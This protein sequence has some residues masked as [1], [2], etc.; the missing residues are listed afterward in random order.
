MKMK[1]IKSTG[2]CIM[3]SRMM[4]LIRDTAYILLIGWLCE[5]EEGCALSTVESFRLFLIIITANSKMFGLTL[6]P[7]NRDKALSGLSARNVLRD[8]MAPSS[9]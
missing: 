1:G 2:H 7:S 3:L 4:I 8:L 9:E 5:L 6:I